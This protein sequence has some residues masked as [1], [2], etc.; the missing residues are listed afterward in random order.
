MTGHSNGGGESGNPLKWIFSPFLVSQSHGDGH[1][2]SRGHDS[3]AS[4]ESSV[5]GKDP[6]TSSSFSMAGSG[7]RTGNDEF[8]MELD[9]ESISVDNR[10][11]ESRPTTNRRRSSRLPAL[12]DSKFFGNPSPFPSPFSSPPCDLA[13]AHLQLDS[14]KEF[15]NGS[16]SSLTPSPS[17]LISL[18]SSDPR[19]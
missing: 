17:F 4:S 18:P 14:F 8:A 5:T 13:S 2:L 1:D 11:S 6:L 7:A 3:R 15:F 19:Q 16:S 9:I 10:F 12:L